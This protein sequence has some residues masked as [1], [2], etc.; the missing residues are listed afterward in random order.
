MKK[1]GAR[2]YSPHGSLLQRGKVTFVQMSLGESDTEC[3]E[4]QI[5][6]GLGLIS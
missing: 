6:S 1:A 2:S 5:S 3:W 4:S